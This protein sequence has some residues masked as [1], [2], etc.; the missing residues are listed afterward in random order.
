M[1]DVDEGPASGTVIVVGEQD[2]DSAVFPEAV[3]EHWHLIDR[4]L[5]EAES[6]RASQPDWGQ[7]VLAAAQASQDREVDLRR[8]A[9]KRLAE[10]LEEP[11]VD[12]ETRPWRRL[13][14]YLQD[15]D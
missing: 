15:L 4:R 10:L 6:I 7:L 8:E 11:A 14:R 9:E 5:R 1:T 12:A 3:R 2:G 13:L